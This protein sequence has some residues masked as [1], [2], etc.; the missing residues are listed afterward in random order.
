MS[1]NLLQIRRNALPK[2]PASAPEILEAYEKKFVQE[3][4]GLTMRN[5][6]K[7]T[8]FF[9]H[10]F[11]CADFSYC[12]FASD[13]VINAAITQV[14]QE[15]RKIYMDGTFRVYPMGKFQ[16]LLIIYVNIHGQVIQITTVLFLS[17]QA[18]GYF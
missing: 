7:K 12:V 18:F 16:Q 11:E 6:G 8:N 13:D 17:L 1:R 5:E 10:A 9:K 15:N 4:Y 14:E 3:N 2:S